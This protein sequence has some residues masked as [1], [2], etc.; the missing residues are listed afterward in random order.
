VATPPIAPL[1]ISG[2][3][4]KHLQKASQ[5]STDS[6]I[7]NLEDGVGNKE[8][9]KENIKEFLTHSN[10]SKKVIVRVNALDEGGDSEIEELSRFPLSA[11]R[12]PKIRTSSDVERALELMEDSRA[13]LHL[14]IETKE[15]W[16]NLKELKVSEK[17]TAFYL[18]ILDLFADLSLPQELIEPNNPT[19]HHILSQ[20]LVTSKALGVTPISFVYQ[21]HKNM[22]T[23][24]EWLHLEKSMGYRAKGALSPTQA[25]EIIGAFGYSDDVIKRA[26]YIVK[27]FEERSAEGIRGFS[28]EKY[29]FI[30]EP[31]YKGAKAV[32]GDSSV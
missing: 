23:F 30:D 20:F 9:A 8:L 26:E 27:I 24:R 21:D 1:M 15:A 2:D 25:D 6:I 13:E 28:D 10:C 4:E 12:V 31:I 7:L 18:G 16:L 29:G 19:V 22:E 17:V 5:L 14:S 11:I 32:L 3:R